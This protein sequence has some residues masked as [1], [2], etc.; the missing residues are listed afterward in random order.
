MN[1]YEILQEIDDITSKEQR[2]RK[3]FTAAVVEI[4]V[5]TSELCINVL[6]IL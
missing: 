6:Q 2:N 4:E 1:F 5:E 3:T